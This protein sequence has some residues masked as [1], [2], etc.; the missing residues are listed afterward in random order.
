MKIKK[1]IG[2]VALFGFLVLALD[3]SLF[4]RG[5]QSGSGTTETF[6]YE[7]RGPSGEAPTSYQDVVLS[8]EDIA[9]VKKGGF[10]AAIL[11]HESTDWVNAVIAGARDTFEQLG[12]EVVAVTDAQMDSNKQR[13]DIE[14]AL[15]LRPDIIV[16]LVVDP[17]SGAVAL[18]Q[19]INQGVKGVLI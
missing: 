16:T 17:V 1:A 18:R 19:A 5:Q 15:A 3:T 12:I 2:N 7:T 14:T 10:K 11:M 9:A 6:V 8:S 4:A 13:T